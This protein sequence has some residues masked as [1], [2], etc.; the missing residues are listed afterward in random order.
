[1]QEKTARRRFFRFLLG[2]RTPL[3]H[4]IFPYQR[5]CNTPSTFLLQRWR[6]VERLQHLQTN[7][8]VLRLKKFKTVTEPYPKSIRVQIKGEGMG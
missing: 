4:F 6:A 3:V 8:T 1:M 2:S 5:C 7:N